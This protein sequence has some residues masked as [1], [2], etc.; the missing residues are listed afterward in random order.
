MFNSTLPRFVLKLFSLNAS[1][2][3]LLHRLYDSHISSYADLLLP[4]M[5]IF[6]S[7][8]LVIS[9]IC[10]ILLVPLILPPI[11]ILIRSSLS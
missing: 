7:L 8:F 9:F 10:L 6:R 11:E 4:S 1:P 3:F 5:A 2:N